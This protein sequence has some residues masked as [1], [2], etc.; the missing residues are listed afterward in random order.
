VILLARVTAAGIVV[1]VIG[2]GCGP[3][4]LRQPEDAGTD[5]PALTPEV[6]AEVPAPDGP[7]PPPTPVA[8]PPVWTASSTGFRLEQITCGAGCLHQYYETAKPSPQQLAALTSLSLEPGSGT[9][10]EDGWWANLSVIDRDG[11][12]RAFFWRY[13]G[14][15]CGVPA[16]LSNR[17][18]QSLAARVPDCFQS[19]AG[20]SRDG[21]LIL[22]FLGGAPSLRLF[23]VGANETHVLVMSH[24]DVPVVLVLKEPSGQAVL[25]RGVRDGRSCS[26]IEYH[27]SEAGTYQVAWEGGSPGFAL[28]GADPVR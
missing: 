9:C 15:S 19:A 13:G 5:A 4:P 1:G 10:S 17:P 16:V 25:A 24:C 11:S 2:G 22:L 18:Y 23:T 12:E 7:S 3:Q 26:R 27:F 28:L 8:L 20:I 21:C 6:T 14:E